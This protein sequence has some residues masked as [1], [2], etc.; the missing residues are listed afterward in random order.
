MA[1]IAGLIEAIMSC[2][3]EIGGKGVIHGGKGVL[4]AGARKIGWASGGSASRQGQ[5]LAGHSLARRSLGSGF[6][7]GSRDPYGRY[8]PKAA[9][10]QAARSG[11]GRGGAS[12]YYS[13]AP[14]RLFGRPGFSAPDSALNR[15]GGS[16]WIKSGGN[17]RSAPPGTR[18]TLKKF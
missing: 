18:S 13:N 12:S 6:G 8:D 9:Y 2:T 14:D 4:L 16:R 7:G 3:V 1:G 11:S 17:K 15:A 10:N 5:R